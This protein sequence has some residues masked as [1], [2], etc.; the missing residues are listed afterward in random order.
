MTP[1]NP[2]ASWHKESYDRLLNHTLPELL[3]SRLP[4][5]GYSVEPASPHTCQ[6]HI[7]ISNGSG[8]VSV[9]YPIPK[10]DQNGVFKINGASL[11]II[12]HVL[13]DDLASAEVQCV[14]ERLFQYIEAQLGEAPENLPWDTSLLGVWMPLDQWVSEFF[15]LYAQVL[16]KTNWLAEQRHLRA[17]FLPNRQALIAPG[18]IG[19][20]CPFETPEGPNI[21]RV[22][23]IAAGAA[24]QDGKIVILDESPE[25]SLGVT[26]CMIPL[27]EHDDPNRL[28]MGSNMMGQWLVPPDPEPALVQTGLEPQVPDF[29]CGR[30]L[31]TAFISWGGDTMEDGIVISE[32][33]AARLKTPHPAEPGD[34]ISNRHG[35]KGVISRILPD[36]QMPHLADGTPVELI[37]SFMGVP[38]RL[39]FGQIRE[40]LWGRVAQVE[41]AP[42]IAPPF[43]A[44]G[45]DELRERMTKAN[46]PGDGMET[47]VIRSTSDPSSN[48]VWVPL[49]CKSTVGWVYWG[50]TAHLAVGKLMGGASASLSN[51]R[52]RGLQRQAELEYRVLRDAKAFENALE[53]FST[54]AAQDEATAGS[55]TSVQDL[56]NQVASGA[57]QQT[58]PPSPSFKILQERLA[59]AGIRAAF[60][61]QSLTFELATSTGKTL[62]LAK[63]VRH[64]WL[65]EHEIGE[66]GV[67]ESAA[68]YPPLVETHTRLA[69]MMASSAPDSLV[70]SAHA[71]LQKRVDDLFDALLTPKDLRFDARVQFSGRTLIAPGPEFSLDQ[72]GLAEELC[73]RLFGPLVV[74]ELG[75]EGAVIKRSGK[76]EKTLDEIMA[77]SWV[78]INRAPS[79]TPTAVLAFHPVR[80]PE[81]V[82]RINPLICPWL[83]A[84]FDGDQVAV[85][86]PITPEGQREAGKRLSVSGHLARNPALIE[87]LAPTKDAIWGLAW[88]SL[89]PEGRDAILEWVEVSMPEGY[90]TQVALEGALLSQL[91]ERGVEAAIKTL[92]RLAAYGFDVI[93]K[94]G[95]SVSP[96]IGE[97]LQLPPMPEEV[98]PASWQVYADQITEQIASRNDFKD[99]DLGVHL[100]MI[101]SRKKIPPPQVYTLLCATRGVVTGMGGEPEVVR[102]SFADGLTPDE[103][104]ACVV[105]SREGLARV[106]SQWENPEQHAQTSVGIQSFNVLAR[107]RRAARP[108]IVFARAAAIGEVDPLVDLDSRLFVG[109]RPK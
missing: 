40:A 108:G 20:V 31:L 58:E 44:P 36:D 14:G 62:L 104:H 16:D 68:E 45:E 70:E 2:I 11:V 3:A 106:V 66:I 22:L 63:P 78:I 101:K 96:F 89:S 67:Y 90:V 26:A 51:A 24:I 49:E 18:H 53:T 84:D 1:L 105:G 52:E 32:S 4:F 5:S 93:K 28:L 76:A 95:A 35:T 64:P 12:P 8:D 37:Y 10:P 57:V 46:L 34:K 86:L 85:F 102:N 69:R 73:W 71:Q 103:M 23:R 88:S 33:T 77:R 100:L 38:G 97:S 55:S 80:I 25:A 41:G 92:E 6:V 107:A 99:P 83:N 65:W 82:V 47:L 43:N 19:R 87:S 56:S 109:L 30:N 60:D 9:Q 75:D 42:V 54:R 21:A 50:K 13:Q 79:L 81:K 15:D 27:L 98:A 61:G 94:S 59:V 48:D 74:R 39:N 91:K 17:V 7:T 72:V 29:W